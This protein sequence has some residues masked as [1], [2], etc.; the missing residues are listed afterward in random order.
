MHA[1]PRS[2]ESISRLRTATRVM[3]VATGVV[4]AAALLTACGKSGSSGTTAPPTIAATATGC[5]P[6]KDSTLVVLTDD[7]K[8]QASDNIVAAVNKAVNNPQLMAALNA[9]ATALDTTKLVALNKTVDVDRQTP[10]AAATAFAQTANLTSGLAKGAGGKILIGAANFSESQEVANLY[11]IVLD[12]IG[13]TS[14]VQTV[15]DRETY[16]PQLEQNKIQIVPEYAASLT[17]YLAGQQK[18]S[19]ASTGDITATMTALTGLGPKA[20]L[21]FGMPSQAADENAFA[22]TKALATRYNLTTMSDF[23]AKCSGT[24][25]VLA[26]PPECPQRPFCQPGLQQT[27]NIQ[28]GLFKSTDAGGPITKKALTDGQATMGLV[29]S[30]DSSLGS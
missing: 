13:Y 4:V 8:L 19:A 24:A 28:F 17:T 15:G 14:T 27:Y 10:A 30:S 16:G 5:A 3:A 18:S 1:V 29:F 25:S 11:K 20:N 7:K 26:G 12:S 23:A 9:V 21:V 2:T 6:I 22:V